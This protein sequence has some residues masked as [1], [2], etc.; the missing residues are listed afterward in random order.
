AA[1]APDGG[2]ERSAPAL[3]RVVPGSPARVRLPRL[4]HAPAGRRLLSGH[5]RRRGLVGPAGE[6]RHE[7]RKSISA[8]AIPPPGA[9]RD[10]RAPPPTLRGATPG[11]D[12]GPSRTGLGVTSRRGDGGVL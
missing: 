6:R 7:L 4:R 10:H 2:A 5:R 9:A 3:E 1:R 8:G 12:L 11:V